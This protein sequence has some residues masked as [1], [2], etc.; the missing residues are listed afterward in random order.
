[1]RIE[2]ALQRLAGKMKDSWYFKRAVRELK[3][4]KIKYISFFLLITMSVM[5]IIGFNRSMNSYVK[6][7][8]V[9]FETNAVEDGQFVVY[10][11]LSKRRI[12]S[13]ESK[14]DINIEE[15]KSYESDFL[16]DVN[17]NSVS[18]DENIVVRVF[19]YEGEINIFSVLQGEMPQKNSQIALDPKFAEKHGF[20]IGDRIVINSRTFDI[21][22]FGISPDY[23]FTLKNMTDMSASPETFGVAYVSD[24]DMSR[25][26]T[27]SGQ[28]TLYCFKGNGGDYEELRTELQKNSSLSSFTLRKD[29]PRIIQVFDDAN[30][31]RQV[32]LVIGLL[33]VIVV[34]FVISISVNNT[35]ANESKTIGIFYALGFKRNELL[36][37]YMLLPCLIVVSATLI[38]AIAGMVISGPLLAVEA[39]YTTPA[40]QMKSSPVLIFSGIILPVA[41]TFLISYCSISRTLNETPLSLL[42]GN[43][44]V[45]MPGSVEKWIGRLDIPFT[46]RFRLKSVVR[47]KR[48]LIVLFFGI[49]LSVYILFTA[50]YLNDS[51]RNFVSTVQSSMPYESMY[52]FG[53][54]RDLN[55]YSVYGETA[56]IKEVRFYDGTKMRNIYLQGIDRNTT[57]FEIP[58]MRSLTDNEV[59]VSLSANKKYGFRKGDEIRIYDDVEDKTYMVT[60][61]GI[62]S[63]DY[64]HYLYTTK[65]GYNRILG[66]HSDSSN[67][68]LTMHSLDIDGDKIQSTFHKSEVVDSLSGTLNMI[69]ILSGIMLWIGGSILICMTVMLLQMNLDKD[70]NNISMIKIFG[71]RKDEINQLYLN[72]TVLILIGGGICAVPM[73]YYTTK[74]MYDGIMDNLQQYFLPHIFFLSFL[75]AFLII[76]ISYR[77]AMYVLAKKIDKIPLTEV[78]KNRE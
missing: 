38:G 23:I 29:N 10:G 22:G 59:L 55:K 42:R 60:V 58:E 44:H 35:I 78:I 15:V 1:M 45:K 69:K 53:D 26:S 8:E 24:K 64:G 52:V 6:T 28:E 63:Y 18:R 50:M 11:K 54:K 73:G 71:Y 30:A 12:S 74:V 46:L 77:V 75:T 68:L 34:A 39:E 25:I 47:E 51:A 62:S 33:L 20:H 48:S 5:I 76:V 13:L 65:E 14:Y 37:Y 41:L 67:A 27:S 66:L 21:T 36:Q 72:G 19:S 7:V 70:K 3:E 31:P 57:M 16:T 40:I 56:A 2:K 43:N 61:A 4:N 17:G 49:T 9:F 32:S